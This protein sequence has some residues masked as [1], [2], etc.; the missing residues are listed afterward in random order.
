V[1]CTAV[2]LRLSCQGEHMNP[3]HSLPRE[4]EKIRF[5][6]S[7]RGISKQFGGIVLAVIILAV[8][9]LAVAGI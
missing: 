9:I 5:L 2:A 4:S 6:I 1:K 3:S 8:A 7:A